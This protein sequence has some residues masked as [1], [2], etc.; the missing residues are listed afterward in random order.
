MQSRVDV[1]L[2][3][4][5][6]R[7]VQ[8]PPNGDNAR[9]TEYLALKVALLEAELAGIVTLQLLQVWTLI[10]FY[11]M[12][13]AI[14][15]SAYFSIGTCARYATA[16][17]LHAHDLF[18]HHMPYMEVEEKRRTWWVIVVLDRFVTIGCPERPLATID[19]HCNDP[20]PRR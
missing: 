2:L 6:M 8:T 9:T 4:A 16:L 7:L 17:G 11:E 12:G 14:Y 18:D 15:P 20:L 10:S 3:F 19:L 13:H 5:C 1:S